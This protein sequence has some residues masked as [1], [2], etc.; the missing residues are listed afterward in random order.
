MGVGIT[1]TWSKGDIEKRLA[2]AAKAYHTA[3]IRMLEYLGE[4]C[5]IEARDHGSYVDHTGNLRSST[6]YVV[7]LNGRVIRRSG[8]ETVSGSASSDVNGSQV[9]L[10]YATSLARGTT[11]YVLTV[12]AGMN[13]AQHVESMGRNV[14]TSAEQLANRELP[15][16]AAELSRRIK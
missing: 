13:Y 5:V 7:S 15:R 4:K 12:V 14:L 9:G 8:F 6:G 16:M 2:A 10:K 1:P 11:G 3:I